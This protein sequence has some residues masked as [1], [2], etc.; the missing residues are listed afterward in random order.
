MCSWWAVGGVTLDTET[1]DGLVLID[2]GSQMFSESVFSCVREFSAS[3]VH[4]CI[5]TYVRGRGDAWLH[6]AA[7]RAAH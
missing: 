2:C 6:V 4:T 3:P 5:Y 1:K 7:V